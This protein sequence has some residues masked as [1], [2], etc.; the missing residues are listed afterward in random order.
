MNWFI[1]NAVSSIQN[2]SFYVML[3]YVVFIIRNKIPFYIRIRS[4]LSIENQKKELHLDL[5]FVFIIHILSIV[6][7][8][9][10]SL[11]Y[12]SYHSF[13]A[14]YIY[15]ALLLIIVFVRIKKYLSYNYRKDV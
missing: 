8:K 7:F 6:F 10:Q 2:I 13:I 4:D 3:V 14:S 11:I 15:V 9:M 5:T 1:Y 12:R